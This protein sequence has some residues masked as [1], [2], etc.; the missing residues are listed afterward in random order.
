MKPK[1]IRDDIICLIRKNV[2]F[3]KWKFYSTT[4][5]LALT[6]SSLSC[7]L[8]RRQ[9]GENVEDIEVYLR[10]SAI[11]PLHAQWLVSMYNFSTSSKGPQIIVKGWKKV[12]ISG[13]L[14]GTTTIPSADPFSRIYSETLEVWTAYNMYY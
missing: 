12:G 6:R 8:I 10:L 4:L 3:K 2:N 13:L 5:A 9:N 11:K 14:D 1:F 7:S